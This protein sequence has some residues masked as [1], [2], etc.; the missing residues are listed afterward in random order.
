[1]HDRILGIAGHKKHLEVRPPPLGCVS[2][3]L[4]RQRTRQDHVGQQ[5]VDPGAIVESGQGFPA[6]PGQSRPVTQ[7]PQLL[8]DEIAHHRVV[9]DH[10]HGLVAGLVQFGRRGG[11]L[12]MRR[13][14]ASRQIEF[15]GRTVPD[16]AVDLDVAIRLLDEAVD[17]A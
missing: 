4:A 3:L 9:L 6:I 17:H 2:D 1:M 14:L 15:Y 11:S 8:H 7:L 13:G 5:Q 12:H 10:Q 16:F